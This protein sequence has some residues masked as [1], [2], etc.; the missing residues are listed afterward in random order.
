[1]AYNETGH[2]KNVANLNLLIGYIQSYGAT[3]APTKTA[4]TLASL[5]DLYTAGNQSVTNVQ[6]AKNNYSTK[7]DNREDAFRDIK[8][9]ST[10]VIGNLSGTNVS[11][12]TIKDAKSINA[13]IQASRASKPETTPENP[14]NDDPTGTT[15]STSRQSY[16]SLYENFHDL[17]SLLAV[18]SDY[19]TTQA[20]FKLQQLT[21]YADTLLQANQ[22]V[23]VTVIEVTNKRMDR[24]TQLYTPQ[25]G[26][27]DTALDAKKYIKGI[28]GASSPQFKTINSISFKNI[29]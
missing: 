5:Q 20:E 16:D 9:F 28:F 13:K 27:V 23:N 29:K 14:E 2:Y 24:N 22:Q 7:V 19:D 17:V 11:V 6:D 10:R 26:L 25:S 8:K 12:Q 21:S 1:M 3:Y 18:V 15:H 4:I